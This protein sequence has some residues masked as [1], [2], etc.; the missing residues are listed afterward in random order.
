MVYAVGEFVDAVEP[1]S[2]LM[3]AKLGGADALEPTANCGAQY[4]AKR[5]SMP[6]LGKKSRRVVS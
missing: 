4:C 3:E 6:L 5:S 2:N 1:I